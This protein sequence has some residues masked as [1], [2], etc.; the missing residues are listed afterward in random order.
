MC[1]SYKLYRNI[2]FH[3][4]SE[5]PTFYRKLATPGKIRDMLSSLN[6]V[7][8]ELWYS[9]P[10]HSWSCHFSALCAELEISLTCVFLWPTSTWLAVI[11]LSVCKIIHNIFTCSDL[12]CCFAH[13]F[14]MFIFDLIY[15][16]CLFCCCLIKVQNIT[17]RLPC[18]FH[19]F[20]Q[21]TS[22]FG[23]S[24]KILQHFE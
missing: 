20:C 9:S 8:L 15:A 6:H 4:L 10:R 1:S 18:F 7:Q 3:N 24:I 19:P 22:Y 12:D 17:V 11:H 21:H 13:W 5:L 23:Y 2:F 14:R 16:R